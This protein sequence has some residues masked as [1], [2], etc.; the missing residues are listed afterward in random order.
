[1]PSFLLFYTKDDPYAHRQAEF[2]RVWSVC[3]REVSILECADFEA[4]T[5]CAD[6]EA[7]PR[8]AWSQTH[9]G[10]TLRVG[11]QCT[12]ILGRQR[13]KDVGKKNYRQS[14]SQTEPIPLWAPLPFLSIWSRK[15]NEKTFTIDETDFSRFYYVSPLTSVSRGR[16]A[17]AGLGPRRLLSVLDVRHGYEMCAVCYFYFSH[18]VIGAGWERHALFSQVNADTKNSVEKNKIP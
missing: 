7:Y 12:C 10:H 14:V 5:G 13:H 8:S 15:M 17:C 9:S 2:G 6:C 16:R 3:F 4:K 11:A 18:R 1:M